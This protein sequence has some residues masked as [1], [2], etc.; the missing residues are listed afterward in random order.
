LTRF[1][2][3]FYKDAPHMY[4]YPQAGPFDSE[5]LSRANFIRTASLNF[6]NP[7]GQINEKTN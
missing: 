2:R 3:I 1:R 5:S 4:S 6:K 7:E